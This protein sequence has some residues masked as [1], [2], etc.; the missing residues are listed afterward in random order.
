MKNILLRTDEEACEA[1]KVFADNVQDRSTV[2]QRKF[3]YARYHQQYITPAPDNYIVYTAGEPRAECYIYEAGIFN[4]PRDFRQRHIIRL[5]FPT[6]HHHCV[7]V[8]DSF[9]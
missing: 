8:Q 9:H 3:D 4:I 2:S 5:T 7:D 1:A 6:T